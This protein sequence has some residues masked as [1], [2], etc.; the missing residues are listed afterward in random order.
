M[1]RCLRGCEPA[2]LCFVVLF[3]N[4][5]DVEISLLG[6]KFPNVY[7]LTCIITNSVS[8]FLFFLIR[9]GW[10][11]RCRSH[12]CWWDELHGLAYSWE[13]SIETLS[14]RILILRIPISLQPFKYCRRCSSFPQGHRCLHTS[15]EF[16]E[17]WQ[18][19]WLDPLAHEA[20]VVITNML[21]VALFF[22]N[23]N[24]VYL[25][26]YY[27]IYWHKHLNVQKLI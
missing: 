17:D 21:I 22:H 6:K 9:N 1:T 7:C 24:T 14:D 8:E 27:R 2:Q 10:F 16:T 11:L 20:Q 3:K 13:L 15:A 5:L 23:Y 4:H 26:D 18:A 19:L 25:S 12:W